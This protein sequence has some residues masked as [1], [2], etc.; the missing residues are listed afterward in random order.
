M[1]RFFARATRGIE[2]IAAAEITGRAGGTVHDLGHREVH[3]SLSA[4]SPASSSSASVLL[5][6]RTVDDVFAWAGRVDGMGRERSSLGALARLP[7]SGVASAL[8]SVASL[9]P[10][11]DAAPFDVVA[12]F[13]GRRNYNRFDIEDAA[14]AALARLTGGSYVSRRAVGA[15]PASTLSWR[16]H[17]RDDTAILGLRLASR[18]LHRRAL[19]WATVPGSLHPPVAA[20]LALLGGVAPGQ[21]LGDP[22]CGSGTILAEYLHLAPT[23]RA[24]GVDTSPDAVAA[25]RA[26]LAATGC[27]DRAL[28]AMADAGLMPLRPNALDVVVTNPPWGRTVALSGLGPSAEARAWQSVSACLARFGRLVVVAE[29]PPSASAGGV[30]PL[31]GWVGP[32]LSFG[33]L[34]VSGSKPSVSVYTRSGDPGGGLPPPGSLLAPELARF[35]DHA[36]G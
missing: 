36:R 14:G 3:F 21:W 1:G 8:A 15:P 28:I 4:S 23:G 17:V 12:S 18:P 7:A 27:D 30:R 32:V 25:A 2:W 33:P 11:P 9:R 19:A 31:P 10:V 5:G 29:E 20:A 34:S 6:L 22:F 26:N 16:I 13:L 35:A 24:V